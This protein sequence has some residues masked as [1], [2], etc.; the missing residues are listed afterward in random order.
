M[1]ATYNK[2]LEFSNTGGDNAI[3][4]YMQ[5][6][7]LTYF[8]GLVPNRSRSLF[9]DF[10]LIIKESGDAP[11]LSARAPRLFPS[12]LSRASRLSLALARSPLNL[13]KACEGGRYFLILIIQSLAITFWDFELIIKES[14]DAPSLSARAPRLFPSPLSRASRLSLALA[15]WPLNLGKACEGGRYFL[16]LILLLVYLFELFL[17]LI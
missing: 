8:L 12:P 9:G 14:G 17:C 15:C 13:G 2:G 4:T 10:E 6:M 1:N 16:I 11:S 7:T 5:F 3:S